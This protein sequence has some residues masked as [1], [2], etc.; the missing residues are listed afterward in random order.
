MVKKI[1]NWNYTE[2]VKF[3]KKHNFY[4]NHIRG[5]HH[6]F[7]GVNN[8]SVKQVCVPY[9]GSESIRPRT[10]NGIIIQSGIT[11]EEWFSN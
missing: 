4:L 1:F 8:G 5:S 9:H 11:K 3:L 6:Y 10:M 2:V 7:V